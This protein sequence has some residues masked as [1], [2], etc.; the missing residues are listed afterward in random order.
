MVRPAGP[1]PMIAARIQLE[2]Q[3]L[4]HFIGI[5]CGNIAFNGR[6]MDRSTLTSEN[7]VAFA[8][9]SWLHTR[10]HTVVSGLFSKSI[11]PASS[12]LFAFKV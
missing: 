10:L 12:N 1:E 6:K 2:E 5:S 11:L 8:L 7:A 3:S 4:G 9:V